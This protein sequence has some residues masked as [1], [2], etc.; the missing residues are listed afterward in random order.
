MIIKEIINNKLD[1]KCKLDKRSFSHYKNTPFTF[2][3]EDS[4][5]PNIGRKLIFDEYTELSE[6]IYEVIRHKVKNIIHVNSKSNQIIDKE[7]KSIE[8]KK[9]KLH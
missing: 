6:G 1:I 4:F 5:E 9:L 3:S 8:D 2:D 7:L